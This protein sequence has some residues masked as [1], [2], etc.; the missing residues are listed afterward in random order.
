MYEILY[1]DNVIKKDLS[2][3]DSV[4]KKKIQE[5]IETKLMSKPEAYGKP[6]RRSLKNYMKLRIG[7]YRVIYRI[8]E[9]ERQV[10]VLVIKHRSAVYATASKRL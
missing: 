2:K 8:E 3:L 9:K 1:E 7:D 6:L 4:W 5:A 10:K